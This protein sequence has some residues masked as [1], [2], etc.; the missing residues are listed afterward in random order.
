MIAVLCYVPVTWAGISLGA[1]FRIMVPGKCLTWSLCISDG[2]WYGWADW[3]P[4]TTRN[5]KKHR[6]RKY[7]LIFSLEWQVVFCVDVLHICCGQISRFQ[8]QSLEYFTISICFM[9]VFSDHLVL[10]IEVRMPNGGLWRRM[11]A[12][13]CV[14]D[15]HECIR[16]HTDAHAC[17][18]GKQNTCSTLG[19][20][21]L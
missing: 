9:A 13:R 7:T 1:K 18:L 20:T 2:R 21:Y 5:N 14:T 16:M 8:T 3:P 6:T 12:R 11:E 10:N 15:A 4:C 17:I 19:H